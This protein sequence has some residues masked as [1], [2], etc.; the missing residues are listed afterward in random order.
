MRR[1]SRCIGGPQHSRAT[2]T[3]RTK[4]IERLSLLITSIIHRYPSHIYPIIP[5]IHHLVDLFIVHT[6]S[7][8]PLHTARFL[9]HCLYCL[10]ACYPLLFLSHEIWAAVCET[11]APFM[12]ACSGLSQCQVACNVG[13]YIAIVHDACN[14]CKHAYASYPR[15]DHPCSLCALCPNPMRTCMMVGTDGD[16]LSCCYS[17]CYHSSWHPS[18]HGSPCNTTNHSPDHTTSRTA[19]VP[20]PPSPPRVQS[21]SSSLWGLLV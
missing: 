11:D 21:S 12:M 16:H 10:F 17:C 8:Q 2:T 9:L 18:C 14:S 1:G 3:R 7:I 6:I 20:P 5:R 13:K 4:A 19:Y 15:Y